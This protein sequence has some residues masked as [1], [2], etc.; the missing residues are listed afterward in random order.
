M[1]TGKQ[2]DSTAE[3]D[4][5]GAPN[6]VRIK[7]SSPTKINNL[8]GN[9]PREATEFTPASWRQQ[10]KGMRLPIRVQARKQT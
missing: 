6:S 2:S 10:R 9:E 7:R 5:V 3:T 1:Y 8:L 4:S